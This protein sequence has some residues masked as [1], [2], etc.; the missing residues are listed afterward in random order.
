MEEKLIY[1]VRD[2]APDS[3]T[4]VIAFAGDMRGKKFNPDG[5]EWNNV[6]KYKFKHL[7][8]K[9]WF[10]PDVRVAWWHT[11]FPGLSGYGPYVLSRYI[12]KVIK[13]MD[14]DTVCTMGLSMGGYGAI[15]M[16]CLIGADVAIAYSPQTWLMEARYRKNNLHN[17]FKGFDIPE[18]QKDLKSFLENNPNNKTIY[19]IYYGNKNSTDRKHAERMKHI[20]GVVLHSINSKKHTVAIRLVKD[21]TVERI[22]SDVTK[23]IY[24]F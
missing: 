15:L 8:F 23:R 16:G 6:L 12:K 24:N 17:K 19:H 2:F 3:K 22:L 11:N 5:P 1:E 9:I 4:L 20:K 18:N 14:V 7:N 21:G 13:D 10:I